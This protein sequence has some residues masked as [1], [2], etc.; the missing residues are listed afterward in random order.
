MLLILEEST[1]FASVSF[2]VCS[3]LNSSQR[4]LSNSFAGR[5]LS[6]VLLALELCR[7]PLL[8]GSRAF[9]KPSKWQKAKKQIPLIHMSLFCSPQSKCLIES[10]FTPSIKALCGLLGFSDFLGN[11]LLMNEQ[12]QWR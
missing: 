11:I 1:K 10:S 7:F 3:L 2:Y 6:V 5:P 12:N 8:F 4:I 9:P